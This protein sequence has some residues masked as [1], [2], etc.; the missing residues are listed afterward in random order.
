MGSA[1]GRWVLLATVL[2][3]GM[4]MLDSTVVNVALVRI[5]ADLNAGF[6][7]LQWTVNGYTLSLAALI[8]LGGSLGDRFGRRRVFVVGVIWF[9]LASLLCGLA[10]TL[11]VLVAARALQGVG[12]ALLTPGSLAIISASFAAADRAAAVGAWSGLAGIAAAVGPFIGGWLV[13]LSWRAVFLIN[14]PVA[15]GIVLVARRHVPESRDPQVSGSVDAP[16]AVLVTAGLAAVTLALTGPGGGGWRPAVGALGVA[17]LVAFGL[18][19]RRATQPLLP[20]SLLTNRPFLAANAVTLFVY[21]ALGVVFVLLVLQLQLVAGFDPLRAGSALLPVTGLMLAFSG[22]AGA[23]AQRIGPRLPMTCGPLLS[24]LGLLALLRVGPRA[25]YPDD[26]LPG[27]LLFGAGLALTVAPLT[28]SV[29]DAADMRRAGTASAVNNAVA[30]AAGLL[31][32][33][34]VPGLA[35]LS[36]AG[37]RD[38][39]RFDQGFRTAILICAGLLAAGGVLALVT[40]RRPP[41][42]NAAPTP[43]A[44][45]TAPAPA[46]TATGGRIPLETCAHCGTTGPQLYP[47]EPRSPSDSASPSASAG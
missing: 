37:Y 14:L 15:L 28:S 3:S 20:P 11:P 6:S 25:S 30:R 33:A 40:I 34:V 23:L 19:E 18:V 32:L 7:G 36:G 39:H 4:A 42:P 31:A 41:A 47:V 29:L 24:A 13:Q 8:L 26:V 21:A 16:G 45:D 12:G 27:L 9:A 17:L 35:G 1:R 46:A 38:P 22:R 43:P 10:P 44:P 5:G 2:G